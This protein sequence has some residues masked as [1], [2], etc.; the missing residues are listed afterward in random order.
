MI[1]SFELSK[2]LGA[3]LA[4][5][6][7]IFAPR[8]AI[9]IWRQ[10]HHETRPGYALPGAAAPTAAPQEAKGGESGTTAFDAASVVAKAASGKPESGAAI[11]KKCLACHTADKAA[12]SKVGPNLWGVVG[13]KKAAR[14]DFAAY[15]EA[16]KTKGGEWTYADLAGFVHN[17]KGWLP[18]TKMIFPGI[19]DS[20]ELS[21]LLAYLRT[22]ADTPAPLPN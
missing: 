15:S 1:D 6:L 2:I 12:A 13:R 16:M 8:A 10:G 22:L 20:G 18:G 21:D 3:A 19:A 7:V 17:P 9:E 4:A 14:E 11:F 5:L